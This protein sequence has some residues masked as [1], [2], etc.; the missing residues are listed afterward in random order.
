MNGTIGEE[1]HQSA[2]ISDRPTVGGLGGDQYL[3]LAASV[4]PPAVKR[5]GLM[6]LV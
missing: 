1:L 3:Q 2:S 4:Q 6:V 5:L